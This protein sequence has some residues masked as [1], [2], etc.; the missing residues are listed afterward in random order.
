MASKDRD[1]RPTNELQE[2]GLINKDTISRKEI[3]LEK[4]FK[5]KVA[6]DR[7]IILNTLKIIKENRQEPVIVYL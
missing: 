3:D 4:Y 7:L 2:M 1:N 6:K 5:E